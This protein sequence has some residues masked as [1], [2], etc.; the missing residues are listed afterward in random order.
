[1]WGEKLTRMAKPIKLNEWK[2][3]CFSMNHPDLEA[4]KVQNYE[5]PLL[6]GAYRP[7]MWAHYGENH[8]GV[9]IRFNSNKLDEQIK[10]SF[11][12]KECEIFCGK[13]EYDD[14]WSNDGVNIFIDLNDVSELSDIEFEEW[15][16]RVYFSKNYKKLFLKKS[17]EWQGEYEFR[18][19]L[20][21]KKDC[22]E[23]M[24]INDIAEEILIGCDFHEAY[25]PSLFK[26][27]EELGIP[28]YRVSWDNGKPERRSIFRP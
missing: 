20:H 24:P 12:D 11:S 16:R 13:V 21:S 6:S 18:W 17:E 9:C 22:P 26:F 14:R 27:C 3:L 23:Y 28:A 8:K 7:G 2:V 19:L 4:E 15:L 1:M 25:Y 10:K 5:N